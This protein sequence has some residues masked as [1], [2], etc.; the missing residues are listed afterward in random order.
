[1]YKLRT[2]RIA[3]NNNERKLNFF[4][5]K[6]LIKKYAAQIVIDKAIPDSNPVLEKCRCQG[7]RVSNIPDTSGNQKF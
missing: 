2:N 7:E 5:L 3:E 4:S 6:L 1:M